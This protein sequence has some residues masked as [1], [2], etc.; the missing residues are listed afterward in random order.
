MPITNIAQLVSTFYTEKKKD[1]IMEKRPIARKDEK[2]AK[3]TI[4]EEIE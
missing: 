1:N 2:N 3:Q 4:W